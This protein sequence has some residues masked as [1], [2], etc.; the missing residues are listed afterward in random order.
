MRGEGNQIAC[1]SLTGNFELK[2]LE[3]NE[4]ALFRFNLSDMIFKRDNALTIQL[5]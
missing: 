5:C 3:F 1:A 2:H 4:Y